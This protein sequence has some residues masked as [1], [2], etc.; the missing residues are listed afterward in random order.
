MESTLDFGLRVTWSLVGYSSAVIRLIR[1]SRDG[2]R[3]DPYEVWGVSDPGGGN[4]P[5]KFLPPSGIFSN[6]PEN[7]CPPRP[8]TKKTLL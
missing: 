5:A 2:R 7:S 8:K 1:A 3:Y 6:P 4:P